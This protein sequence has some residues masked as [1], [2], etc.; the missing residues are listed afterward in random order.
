VN[1]QFAQMGFSVH[2]TP[3]REILMGAP[4]VCLNKGSL[5]WSRPTKYGYANNVITA[6]TLKSD[7]F[8]VPFDSYFGF[9]ITSGYFY[10]PHNK[11]LVYVAMG[12]QAD[13]SAGA[14]YLFTFFTAFGKLRKRIHRKLGGQSMGEYFGYAVVAEDFDGDGWSGLV[15]WRHRWHRHQVFVLQHNKTNKKSKDTIFL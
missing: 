9:A 8:T 13:Q 4:G 12:P 5:V 6:K 3:T 7:T 2:I 14:V 11:T 15:T 1:A 10:G